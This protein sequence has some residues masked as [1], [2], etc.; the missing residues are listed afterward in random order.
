MDEDV[1]QDNVYIMTCLGILAWR[2]RIVVEGRSWFSV[3]KKGIGGGVPQRRDLECFWKYV[4]PRTGGLK[5]HGLDVNIHDIN[6][7][8]LT[9]S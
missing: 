4:S 8:L 6:A 9:N 5:I 2:F 1:Y 3:V 7:H